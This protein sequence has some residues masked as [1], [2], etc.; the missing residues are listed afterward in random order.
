[1]MQLLEK[2]KGYSRVFQPNLANI[3]ILTTDGLHCSFVASA[4]RR[5]RVD[6]IRHQVLEEFP[7]VQ[8]HQPVLYHRL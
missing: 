1:M 5:D 7:A 6:H 4:D 3:R 2:L 8:A